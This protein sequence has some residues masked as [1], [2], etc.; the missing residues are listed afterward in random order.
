MLGGNTG[1]QYFDPTVSSQ[2][3]VDQVARNNIIADYNDSAIEVR[4]VLRGYI[5][6]NTIVG[7]SPYA[8]FRLQFGNSASG[9]QSGNQQIT[10]SDNLVVNTASTPLLYAW[11]DGN[12]GSFKVGPQLWA[13][14]FKQ[15]EQN[16]LPT[17]PQVFDI[18][19]N[20]Y[21]AA[22][23]V[24]NPSDDG[25]TGLDDARSRYAPAAGSPALR[26]GSGTS[27]TRYDALGAPRSASAPTLGAVEQVQ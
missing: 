10:I 25:L 26:S 24:R 27:S 16:G 22:K 7:D 2:E 17:F 21:E 13:G 1:A 12:I 4:G 20:R 5:Y 23:V 6:H 9:G 18:H 14:L 3:G 19:V 15:Y 8:A 11:N